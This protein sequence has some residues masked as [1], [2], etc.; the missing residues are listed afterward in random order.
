MYRVSGDE[1][2]QDDEG[3]ILQSLEQMSTNDTKSSFR[4]GEDL[5]KT[6]IALVDKYNQIVGT[7]SAAKLTISIDSSYTNN[8]KSLYN[9][10]IEGTTQITATNGIFTVKDISFAGTPGINYRVVLTTDGIDSTKPSNAEY[11]QEVNKGSSTANNT[12]ASE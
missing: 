11:A 10:I 8:S 7:D 1:S 5:P 6:Y 3:R 12:M 2:Y 4:S 9:P